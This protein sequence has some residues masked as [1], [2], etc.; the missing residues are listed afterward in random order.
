MICRPELA[1]ELLSAL[2][3]PTSVGVAQ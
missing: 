2:Q 1:D 3:K